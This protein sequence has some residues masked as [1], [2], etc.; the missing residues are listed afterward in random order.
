MGGQGGDGPPGPPGRAGEAARKTREPLPERADDDGRGGGGRRIR[1]AARRRRQP[2]RRARH[3]RPSGRRRPPR[4]GPAADPCSSAWPGDSSAPASAPSASTAPIPWRRAS[5]PRRRRRTSSTPRPAGGSTRSSAPIERLS[6]GLAPLPGRKSILVL[7]ENLL[8]RRIHGGALPVGDR[9]RP[10]RQHVRLLHGGA[11][12]HRALQLLGGRPCRGRG[13]RSRGHERGAEPHRLCRGR[14][15]HGGD[16]RDHVA[17]QRSRR[18]PRPD[19]HGPLRVLPAGLPARAQRLRQVAQARGPR[20]SS[21]RRGARA[22]RIPR[23]PADGRARARQEESP[24]ARGRTSSPTLSRAAR[25]TSSR[26]AWPRACRRPTRGRHA[27]R[28]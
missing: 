9:R 4:C 23:R 20:E 26:C 28:W 12:P 25:A 13:R 1:I 17:V 21:R 2:G 14:A 7:S 24:A 18:R 5:R 22:P 11:R 6:L 16:G 15:D 19:G 3:G 8:A 10:T 27:S